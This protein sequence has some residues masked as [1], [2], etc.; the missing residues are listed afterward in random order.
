LAFLTTLQ[1]IILFWLIQEGVTSVD[2]AISKP[3]HDIGPLS[4]QPDSGDYNDLAAWTGIALD[5]P[6]CQKDG[7]ANPRFPLYLQSYNASA[8]QD[9]W[10]LFSSQVKGDSPFNGSIFMFEGYPTQA[11]RAAAADN[12]TAFA[13]RDAN[14]LTAP[15]ITYEPAG[16]DLDQKAKD[17][18]ERLR[19]VLF[20]ASGDAEMRVY[21]NYAYGDE[22]AKEWYGAEA[23]RQRRL[24]ALKHKYDPQGRFSFFAPVTQG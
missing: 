20:K 7:H 21:V 18:G 6:P 17:L 22:N 12:S 13:F 10:T 23:W 11:V 14:L 2:P 15:L 24:A 3:F 16:P 9:A 5:S 1:P 19:N 8:M 4:I